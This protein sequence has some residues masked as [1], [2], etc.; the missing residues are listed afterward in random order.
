MIFDVLDQ[1][2][3]EM[4][5]LYRREEVRA[6]QEKQAAVDRKYRGLV[7]EANL[8]VCSVG[9]VRDTLEFPVSEELR[10]DC[11]TLLDELEAAVSTGYAV[12]ESVKKV[13]RR[14]DALHGQMKKAWS[15]YFRSYTA[16]TWNTLRVIR[17]IDEE[18]VDRYIE[19]IE[20]AKDWSAGI[21]AFAGLM[22]TL[23]YAKKLIQSLEME[24]ETVEFLTK[25]TS[26]KATAADLSE[27]VVAWLR[28]EGLE[29]KI[30]LSFL[31]H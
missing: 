24:E 25:M 20:A 12:Q 2:M 26:G 31:A 7:E 17:S 13:K 15:A 19:Q 5:D 16:G 29:K 10:T 30:R 28:K 21:P 8:F 22:A 14:Y 9:F 1:K 4:K 23:M 3:E 6:N 18:T 11:L 27:G